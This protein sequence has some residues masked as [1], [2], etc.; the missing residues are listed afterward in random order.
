[1][2]LIHQNLMVLYTTEECNIIKLKIKNMMNNYNIIGVC[3]LAQ[4]AVKKLL[5]NREPIY[6]LTS[7]YYQQLTE[8]RPV[9]IIFNY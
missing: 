1:M 6:S 8:E 9:A 7:R 5:A 3:F 2:L 4:L